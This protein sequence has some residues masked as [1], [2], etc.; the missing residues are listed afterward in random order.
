MF[1]YY[2][3]QLD[4][5]LKTTSILQKFNYCKPLGCDASLIKSIT[6]NDTNS[7]KTC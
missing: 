4:Y 7:K 5:F 6:E 3:M 2:A 1:D